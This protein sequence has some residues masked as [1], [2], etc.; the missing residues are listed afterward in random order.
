[1]PTA[2]NSDLKSCPDCPAYVFLSKTASHTTVA[3][4]WMQAMFVVRIFRP[5]ISFEN[6]RIAG[7]Q[8]KRKRVQERKK[9]QIGHSYAAR[10]M[11]SLTASQH[12]QSS[13]SESSSG[14]NGHDSEV[15]VTDP[16][17]L[18]SDDEA[19]LEV[20]QSDH[21]AD[22]EV[23]HSDKEADPVGSQEE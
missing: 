5:S 10:L 15:Q 11:Q 1:M 6:R 22:P 20:L 2:A 7:H 21:E 16:E 9:S 18:P 14:C 19:D 23:V 12:H 4:E 13:D 8:R 3:T 17:M